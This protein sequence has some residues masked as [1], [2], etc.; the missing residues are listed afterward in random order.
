MGFQEHRL[1]R[2]D[3]GPYGFQFGRAVIHRLDQLRARYPAGQTCYWRSISSR[4]ER[5][6]G[7]PISGRG[8]C[9][10]FPVKRKFLQP[11]HSATP[12]LCLNA[13]RSGPIRTRYRNP[14]SDQSLTKRHSPAKHCLRSFSTPTNALQ[15]PTVSAS[16]YSNLPTPR[17]IGLSSPYAS[18]SL[19]LPRGAIRGY[20]QSPVTLPDLAPDDP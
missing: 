3:G 5:L 17:G 19:S 14:K 12:E 20:F 1:I 8:P 4:I 11:S 18:P 15:R 9:T 2:Q 16:R 7:S 6:S 13:R 10:H